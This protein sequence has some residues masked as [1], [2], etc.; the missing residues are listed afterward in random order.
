MAALPPFLL[1]EIQSLF[2]PGNDHCALPKGGVF[3]GE[4]FSAKL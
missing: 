1:P 4:M 3:W 2:S